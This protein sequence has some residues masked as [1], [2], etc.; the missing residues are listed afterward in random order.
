MSARQVRRIMRAAGFTRAER[1]A[2]LAA[3][4]TDLGELSCYQARLIMTFYFAAGYDLGDALSRDFAD[5]VALQAEILGSA[6]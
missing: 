4:D 2:F 3:W 5:A 6:P 1:R